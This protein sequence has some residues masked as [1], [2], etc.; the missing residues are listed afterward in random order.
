MQKV[1]DDLDAAHEKLGEALAGLD[2]DTA[3][4]T[5]AVRLVIKAID[6]IRLLQSRLEKIQTVKA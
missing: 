6:C 3:V 5:D 2:I 4:G 1:I